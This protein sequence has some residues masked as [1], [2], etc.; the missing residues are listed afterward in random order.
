M[1]WWSDSVSKSKP[2]IYDVAEAAGVSH[3]TVSRVINHHHSVRPETRARVEQA[4]QELGYV[5]NRAAR[6]LV[7]SKSRLIGILASDT[8]LYGPAGMLHA[9]DLEARRFGYVPFACSV[10]SHS[11]AEVRAG[12]EHLRQ[13]AVDGVILITAAQLPLNIA[14][15]G[16][17]GIPIVILEADEHNNVLEVNVD[18]Y[19][20]AI[21]A[22]RHLIE[23]GHRR[24]LHIGGVASWAVARARQRGY[25]DAMSAAGLPTNV[26]S[27]DWQIDTGYRVGREYDF[28]GNGVTAVF[29]ANDHLALGLMH[30]CRDR[31]IAVPDDLSVV[32][33]DDIPEA[34]HL[35]P[36][37]TTVRQDFLAMGNQ[38]LRLLM[39]EL[40]EAPAVENPVLPL[41]FIVRASTAPPGKVMNS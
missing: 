38:G 23:L 1:P 39:A 24:I 26:V 31:G 41:E 40:G 16:L 21:T 3:Q 17:P 10:D 29:C 35:H 6:A 37:L 15:A 7:T 14:R 25:E 28:A 9:I 27:G 4:M 30:A 34:A 2:N 36:P 20:A 13:M 19:G 12:V 5:P 18:N 33:F 32:G 22:T 11:E 8:T